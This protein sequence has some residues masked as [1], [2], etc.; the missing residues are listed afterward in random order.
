VRVNGSRMGST[1]DRT[2]RVDAPGRRRHRQGHL[3]A[4]LHELD[5]VLVHLHVDPHAL[6]RQEEVHG[7]RPS[8]ATLEGP[9]R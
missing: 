2:A 6:A 5:L 7:S 1:D 4:R 3:L 9:R 8:G